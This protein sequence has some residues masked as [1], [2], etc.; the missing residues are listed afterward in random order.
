MTIHFCKNGADELRPEPDRLRVDAKRH[1]GPARCDL[2]RR[3]RSCVHHDRQ[4]TVQCRAPAE[5]NWGDSVLAL[6]PDGTGS[7]GGMPVDS[8][9]PTT[10]QN[11]QNTDADLGSESIAIVPPPPGTAAQYQHIAVQAGKDGCVRL[12]NLA[13][14]SG[15]GAPAKTGG[16]LDAKN[17]P[18]GRALRD[19]QRRS[20]D[21]AAAGGLGQS[22]RSVELDLTLPATAT[23]RQLQDRAG[24]QRQAVAGEQWPSGRPTSCG[25]IIRSSPT[26]RSTT[27][28]DRSRA[29]ARSDVGASDSR[30][31]CWSAYVDRRAALA[32]PDPRQWPPVPV[33]RCNA[34]A[35][36]WVFQLDGAFKSGF[37]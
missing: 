21:Q 12:I 22:G 3:H 24:R 30:S 6:N 19:R 5:F 15:Q 13:D 33:R 14:L 11:L 17:L 23:V 27:C 26:E 8:Y 16:E 2:R 20:G 28:P 35:K 18:G 9:T 25:T 36:L 34:V 32:E 31:A 7:G 1:L 4:R 37:D 29:C 10:F